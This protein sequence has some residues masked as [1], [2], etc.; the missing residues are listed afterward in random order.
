MFNHILVGVDGS[1]HSI[2]AAKMAGELARKISA[3]SL[4]L[5]AC[6]DAAL[7]YSMMTEFNSILPMQDLTSRLISIAEDN[8][9]LAIEEIGDLPIQIETETSEGKPAESILMAARKY[10]IDLIVMGTRGLG[11]LAGLLLGSQ[12]QKVVA[13]ADCPVLLV[14]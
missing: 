13:H 9:K 2:K 5:V 14:R 1:E 3:E 4:H 6:Y 8:L 7:Q 11:Q 10:D 12:S